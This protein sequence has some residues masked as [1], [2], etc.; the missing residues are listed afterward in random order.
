MSATLLSAWKAATLRLAEAGVESP[1][2]DARLL[3]E[4]A[5][6][7]TRAD[8]LTDPYRALGE[9][10]AARLEAM[11]ARRARREPVSLILGVRPFWTLTLG[12][13][14]GVLTPRP[15]TETVLDVVLPAFAA[16]QAFEAL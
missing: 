15:E 16:D 8:I 3:V 5:V 12:V 2:I 4:A 10:S 13:R 14:P 1:A 11:I 7:V 9:Q 6:P